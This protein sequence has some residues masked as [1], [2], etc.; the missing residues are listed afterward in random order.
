ML[1]KT[2][3]F[4]KSLICVNLIEQMTNAIRNTLLIK[5]GQ[6]SDGPMGINVALSPTSS[7]SATTAGISKIAIT[8]ASFR[9]RKLPDDI[10]IVIA[11]NNPSN[12]GSNQLG[13]INEEAEEVSEKATKPTGI[14]GV[15]AGIG[16][17]PVIQKLKEIKDK[18]RDS[19]ISQK[20]TKYKA[21]NGDILANNKLLANEDSSNE[22]GSDTSGISDTK[23]SLSE[24]A[25]PLTTLNQSKTYLESNEDNRS[26]SSGNSCENAKVPLVC[27][28]SESLSA[29]HNNNNDS[30]VKV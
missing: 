9:T 8:N 7:T 1:D 24:E 26:E 29:K 25:I 22:Y 3:G 12:V 14:K 27:V 10:P 2:G 30:S 11:S 6:P 15:T 20:S 4:V 28:N 16:K 5:S 19:N 23:L 17:I 13:A 21:E 18:K